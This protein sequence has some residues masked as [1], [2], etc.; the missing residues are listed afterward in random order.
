MPRPAYSPLDVEQQE[1]TRTVQIPNV[2]RREEPSRSARRGRRLLR[3]LHANDPLVAFYCSC[4]VN[5][6]QIIAVIVVFAYF[7]ENRVCSV[8]A[9]RQWRAWGIVHALRLTA[10]TLVSAGR[11]R[12][13]ATAGPPPEPE[14]R[15]RLR[16]LAAN[17]RNSLD[18]LALIWFVVGNMWLLGS[19]PSTTS[20]GVCHDAGRSP[21]YVTDVAMLVIQYA[22]ICLPCLFAV[23]MVPVFCF[24]LPCVIRL[25]A[26]LHDPQHGR[27]ATRRDLDK[28]PTCPFSADLDLLKGEEP[29]CPVC[30]CDY[31]EN[32]RLRVLPCSHVF[33][34]DCVDQWLAV[35]ATCPLC[36]KSIFVPDSDVESPTPGVNLT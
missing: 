3:L 10:G 20:S 33:H 19:V 21:V 36:R 26:A 8:T 5:L 31:E 7:N 22:Q 30:I 9:R 35:N 14:G 2:L 18:A 32:D 17:A 13:A 34:A 28:L 27:G 12:L 25:L 29:C 1:E 4:L 23:A 11:A 24:C 6:P 15:R 16:A